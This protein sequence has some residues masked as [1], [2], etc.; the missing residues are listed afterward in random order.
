MNREK[1]KARAAEQISKQ[2]EA[3]ARAAYADARRDVEQECVNRINACNERE[4]KLSEAESNFEERRRMFD[5]EVKREVEIL[6]QKRFVEPKKVLD[7]QQQDLEMREK[8]LDEDRKNYREELDQEYNNAVAENSALKFFLKAGI[9]V[10]VI[11]FVGI[12][13]YWSSNKKELEKKYAQVVTYNHEYHN[14][15]EFLGAEIKKLQAQIKKDGTKEK[16]NIEKVVDAIGGI[17]VKSDFAFTEDSTWPPKHYYYKKGINH[18]NGNQA[19]AFARER[20]VFPDGDVQRVKNQ[21]KVITA[22]VDKISS[23]ATIINNYTKILDAISSSFATNLDTKSINRLVK[24]QLSDMRG[25]SIDSQN[26][27]GYS[28]TS[29]NCYSI[30]NWNLYVMKQN[31]ESVKTAS[32]KIKEF[33][34][35]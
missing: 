15:N 3:R 31:P 32:D 22:I 8:K 6:F 28:A 1:E 16:Y 20:L 4:K 23:S 35:K 11:L 33:I 34:N 29:K 12:N 19:L 17:D 30:P 13:V 18:L 9:Y 26:L 24:M 14:A 10:T 5:D 25:W 21:Q 7:K 27:V 2:A